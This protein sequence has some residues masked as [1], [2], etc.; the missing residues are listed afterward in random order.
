MKTITKKVALWILATTTIFALGLTSVSAFGWGGG[1]Q[2]KGQGGW[3]QGTQQWQNQTEESGHG[4]DPSQMLESI[5]KQDLDAVEIDLLMKQYEEEMMANELYSSFYEMYGIETFQKIA[6]SEAKHM[7]AVKALLDRYELDVPTNYDHIQDLYEELKASWANSAF[8][9]LEV[10]VK[11]EFV[12][13]DDIVTAIKSTDNEDIKVV[14][15]N[16]WGGSYN[17]L[18]GFLNAIDNEGYETELDWTPYL[19]ESDLSIKG[20]I[21][22]KLSEKLE[23]DWVELPE[24]VSSESM[25]SKKG[26]SEEDWDKGWKWGQMGKWKSWDNSSRF[27]E[28]EAKKNSYKRILNN[29]YWEKIKSFSSEESEWIITKIDLL[30]EDTKNSEKSEESKMNTASL[31]LALKEI[32][33]EQIDFEEVDIDN[34]LN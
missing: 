27:V 18:R 33:Q 2:G 34:L 29:K 7:D 15:T 25:K 8:D 16:I 14:L 26:H 5:E 28:L 20:P 22:Y 1:W 23:E 9:A 32:L 3:G 21:K 13:I 30:I 24:Q 12:D 31:L 4:E 10:W 11:I 6:E 19:E 17:H